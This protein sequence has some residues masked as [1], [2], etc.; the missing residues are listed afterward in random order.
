MKYKPGKGINEF[1]EVFSFGTWKSVLPIPR[2]YF[3]AHD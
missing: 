1:L 3:L 2:K